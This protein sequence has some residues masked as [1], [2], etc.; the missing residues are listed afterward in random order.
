MGVKGLKQFVEEN[1]KAL[2][3]KKIFRS[4]SENPQKVLVVDGLSCLRVF[5]NPRLDWLCG[6]QWTELRDELRGFVGRFQRAGFKLVFI[7]DG[8]VERSKRQLWVQRRKQ[9]VRNIRHVLDYVVETGSQPTR[10]MFCLPAA[11]ST[12][13]RMALKSVGVE[14]I[15]SLGEADKEIAEYCLS[16]NCYGVLGDDSDYLIYPIPRYFT[17]KDIHVGE[18]RVDMICYDRQ[19]LCSCLGISPHR[20][21][22][23]A[24]LCGNDILDAS[25]LTGFHRRLTGVVSS[26]KPTCSEVVVKVAKFIGSF[27]DT[28]SGEEIATRAFGSSSDHRLGL[29]KDVLTMYDL[30]VSADTYL[31]SRDAKSVCSHE[32]PIN[33]DVPLEDTI[34]DHSLDFGIETSD[35]PW[36]TIDV[37]GLCEDDGASN[38]DTDYNAKGLVS[39]ATCDTALSKDKQCI[40]KDCRHSY[41]ESQGVAVHRPYNQPCIHPT[42]MDEARRR[43]TAAMMVHLVYQVMCVGEIDMGPTLEDPENRHNLPPAAVFFQPIRERLYGIVLGVREKKLGEATRQLSGLHDENDLIVGQNAVKEWC[44]YRGNA[45]SKADIVPACPVPPHYLS[46]EELWIG[47]RDDKLNQQMEAFCYCLGWPEMPYKV[48]RPSRLLLCGVLHFMVHQSDEVLKE[49]EL[50]AFLVQATDPKLYRVDMLHKLRI[51][52][53]NCRSVELAAMFMRGLYV[54]VFAYNACGLVIDEEVTSPWLCFNGKLFHQKYLEVEQGQL[55]EELC[56]HRVGR[57]CL[58]LCV[59]LIQCCVFGYVDTLILV[60]YR[61]Y[62]C[63]ISAKSN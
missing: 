43:H 2:T 58:D 9:D 14:V 27:S 23:L 31:T 44:V 38:S 36:V 13:V 39:D 20:M 57:L 52:K 28:V 40:A 45:M 42:V 55:L 51:H 1:K 48:L 18:K 21:P 54:A 47:H 34:V 63:L 59:I 22:V 37:D 46:L 25:R 30:T 6:G 7:F 10:N 11:L 53:P 61:T 17:T 15:N 24:G 33:S 5:Y 12:Y 26:E 62:L 49:W 8:V 16:K 60:Q 19:N 35:K 32:N 56:A 41:V 29:F 4:P 50:N 3:K